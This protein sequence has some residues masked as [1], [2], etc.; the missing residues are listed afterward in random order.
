M[1]FEESVRPSK[2]L[3][4]QENIGSAS[5]AQGFDVMNRRIL[6]FA[7]QSHANPVLLSSRVK[8]RF[9]ELVDATALDPASS[10]VMDLDRFPRV[11]QGQEICSLKSFPQ[12]VG[13]SPAA[14]SGKPNLGYTDPFAYQANKSSFYPLA[15]HGIRSTHVPYQNPYNAGIQSSGRPSRAINFGEE[16]KKSD[17]LN[18]SGLP[19]NVTVDLPFR[20]GMLGKQKG[21][22]FN[23]NASS[24][25]K[26]FGFSLPVERPPSNPR[27]SSKRICTK[28]KLVLYHLFGLKLHFYISFLINSCVKLLSKGSQARKPSGESY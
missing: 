9:G 11:L 7:M 21:G 10:G 6:D 14:T 8:D 27:S 23:M 4:G 24:G 12:F 19:N 28:V 22:D 2:V 15:L 18:E 5:P 13:F 16:T 1:D 17:A 3:Q 20:I 26:L 25:C